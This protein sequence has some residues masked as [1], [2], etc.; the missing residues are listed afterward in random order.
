MIVT[1][2]IIPLSHSNLSTTSQ[3]R[4]S[5]I[6]SSYATSTETTI[7]CVTEKQQVIEKLPTSTIHQ[8]V[9]M[10]SNLSLTLHYHWSPGP[11]HIQEPRHGFSQFRVGQPLL[12][13]DLT[14]SS[15]QRPLKNSR[16]LYHRPARRDPRPDLFLLLLG[17]SPPPHCPPSKICRCPLERFIFAWR[18]I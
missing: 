14:D 17:L 18:T 4:V 11:S 3:L 9:K 2:N 5:S 13:E 8:K 6:T 12:S 7:L 15:I 16:H 1:W 10:S